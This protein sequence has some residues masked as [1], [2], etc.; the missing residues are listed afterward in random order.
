MIAEDKQVLLK[1]H[2]QSRA[3]VLEKMDMNNL[4]RFVWT[5]WKWLPH[6]VL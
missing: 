2:V 6:K 4:I 1:K 3:A 5:R